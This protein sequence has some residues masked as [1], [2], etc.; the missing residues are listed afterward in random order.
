MSYLP[1]LRVTETA[2]GEE[3]SVGNGS[4]GNAR[5]LIADK[6]PL[7]LRGLRASIG[8]SYPIVGEAATSREVLC[9]LSLHQPRLLLM[10]FRLACGRDALGLASEFRSRSQDTAIIVFLPRNASS[11]AGR[12]LDAGIHGVLA[13]CTPFDALLS[14]IGNVLAGEVF[15]DPSLIDLLPATRHTPPDTTSALTDRERE[16]FHLLGTGKTCKDIAT[17]LSIST[18]TVDRHLENIKARL[19]LSTVCDVCCAAKDRV[20]RESSGGDYF[21]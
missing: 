19:H 18:K 1:L 9:Q 6:E 16:V 20:L 21:I 3:G 14:A 15:A 8:G 5:I 10:G 13:R 4:Q 11:F 17:L 2:D 12:L 7:F